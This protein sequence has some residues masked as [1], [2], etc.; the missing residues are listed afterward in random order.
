MAALTEAPIAA[1]RLG[2][3]PLPAVAYLMVAR[4]LANLD[5]LDR[6]RG[7][8]LRR[9]YLARP[10][11]LERLEYLLPLPYG[12]ELLVCD[13]DRAWVSRAAAAQ[14]PCGGNVQPVRTG[15][16]DQEMTEPTEQPRASRRGTTG[17]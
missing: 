15:Q 16:V 2:V 11:V 7:E 12:A 6:P 1:A 9:A 17:Q 13:C 14:C 10:E 5:G 8:V 3:L 4:K